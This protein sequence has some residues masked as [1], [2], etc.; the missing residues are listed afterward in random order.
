MRL[1][2]GVLAVYGETASIVALQRASI[3]NMEDGE[4]ERKQFCYFRSN[5]PK[6]LTPFCYTAGKMPELLGM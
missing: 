3:R 1:P 6:R 5:R 4:R 2:L